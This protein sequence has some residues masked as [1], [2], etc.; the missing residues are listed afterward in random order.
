MFF[1]MQTEE[2]DLSSPKL[3]FHL[4]QD[5][6][7]QSTEALYA[8]SNAGKAD[9]ERDEGHGVSERMDYGRGYLRYGEQR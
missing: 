6:R 5:S 9:T 7:G 2:I 3:Q 4:Q 1:Q 8:S